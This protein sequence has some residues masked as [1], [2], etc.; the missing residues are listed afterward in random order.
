MC[1]TGENPSACF[2]TAASMIVKVIHVENL[3]FSHIIELHR[4][5]V[6]VHRI[7]LFLVLL[8]NM[9][10]LQLVLLLIHSGRA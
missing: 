3:Q 9:H 4:V 10:T 1:T 8:L 6:Q 5:A 2:C 7:Y